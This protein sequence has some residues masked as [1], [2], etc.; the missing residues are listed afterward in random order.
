MKKIGLFILTAFAAVAFTGCEPAAN[1][2]ANSNAGTPK[3]TA[4]APTKEAFFEMDKKATEAWIKGDKAHFEGMLSD[5]FVSFDH[6][7][8]MDKTS[9]LAMIGTFKCDV[10]TWSLDDPQM[11]MIDADTYVFS[12]KGNYD[13]T[14]TGPDGKS[15]K[16]PSPVRSASV[17]VRSGDTWKGA[18]HSETPIIDPKAA[19]AAPAKAEVKKA[20]PKPAE[21][22][23]S[24]SAV[25]VA[26]DDAETEKEKSEAAKDEKTA[27]SNMKKEELKKADGKDAMPAAAKVTPSANT[28]ALVKLHQAGW[29]AWKAKDAKWF[30]ANLTNTFSFVDAIG[31]WHGGGKAE[32]TKIWT[33]TM[34]CEGVTSVKVSDGVATALS[35]TVEIL[36]LKGTANGTCDGQKNAPLHQ[37]AVYVKEGA[38]WKL[39]FMFEAPAM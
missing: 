20:E 16:L 8:R 18:F 15:M 30:D 29:D 7:M 1:T 14:C 26:T 31:L 17:W 5:K 27:D 24:L 37:T 4:A 34:K 32:A 19:P 22:K 13:G 21:P 23:T 6:G 10:K 12:S 9:L 2:T 33:E 35:P 25:D 3:P 28:D 38:A 36:T 11:S 39:A